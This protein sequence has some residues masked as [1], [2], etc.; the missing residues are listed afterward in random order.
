MGSELSIGFVARQ[1]GCTVPTIRYYESIGLLPVARRSEA[2]QRHFDAAAVRRLSFV[3]RC[4]EFGFSID[5]VRE[6]VGLIDHPDRPCAQAR[7]IASA[8]LVNVQVRMAELRALEAGLSAF[9]SSCNAAC[10]GGA[11]VDCTILEDLGEPVQPLSTKA[12]ACCTRLG[13]GKLP[14]DPLRPSTQ[15]RETSR[16]EG[17]PRSG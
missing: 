14:A 5:Q 11:V 12:A 1:T 10:V 7:D 15:P 4:R 2:G 17:T 13:E 9:V 8:Q 16:H 3:R 6:L